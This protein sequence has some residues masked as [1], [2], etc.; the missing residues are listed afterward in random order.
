[1]QRGVVD[2]RPPSWRSMRRVGLPGREGKRWPSAPMLARGLTMATATGIPGTLLQL[3]ERTS[4][5]V[6]ALTPRRKDRQVRHQ[7][8]EL[9]R[10]RVLPP[11]IADRAEAAGSQFAAALR[12]R[13]SGGSGERG[14]RSEERGG[15]AW[16]ALTTDF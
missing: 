9:S 2:A 7:A 15:Q 1:M 4:V 13:L 8:G 5:R 12:R 14:A 16:L 6:N 3:P 10:V 11:I